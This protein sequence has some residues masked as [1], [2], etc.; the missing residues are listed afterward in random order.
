[1]AS[2]EPREMLIDDVT[3]DGAPDIVTIMHDRI[4]IYPQDD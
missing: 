2:T 4:V 3:G 1:M